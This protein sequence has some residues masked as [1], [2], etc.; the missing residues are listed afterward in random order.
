LRFSSRFAR[1]I[2]AAAK[3]DPAGEGV[4]ASQ[5]STDGRDEKD[6]RLGPRL[7]QR[8]VASVWICSPLLVEMSKDVLVA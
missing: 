2:D 4:P 5:F 6:P 7:S 8:L 3:F 1:N